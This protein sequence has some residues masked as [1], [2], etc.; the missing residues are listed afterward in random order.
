LVHI[1]FGHFLGNYK[2][3]LMYRREKVQKTNHS[4]VSS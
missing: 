3:F 2:K 4:L 1:D